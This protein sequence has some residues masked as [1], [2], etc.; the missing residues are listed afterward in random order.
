MLGCWGPATPDIRVLG[1][2]ITGVWGAGVQYW[3]AGVLVHQTLGCWGAEVPGCWGP[4]APGTGV[5]GCRR[6]RAWGAGVQVC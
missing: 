4:G 2:R 3:G 6:T 5:L 1:C